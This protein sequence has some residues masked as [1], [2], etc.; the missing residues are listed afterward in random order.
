MRLSDEIRA[1]TKALALSVISAYTALPR[2]VE[3][4]AI[5]GRQFVRAGTSIAAHTREASRA[6]S[7]A[8]FLAKLELLLQEADETRLW[9]ELLM[10]GCGIT[11][12]KLTVCHTE[13]GEILGIFTTMVVNT[14]R[15]TKPGTRN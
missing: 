4:V 13:L 5:L 7:D 15:R 6:R 1:R 8:E 10:E 12:E 11:S 14:K 2:K 9:A 3:V